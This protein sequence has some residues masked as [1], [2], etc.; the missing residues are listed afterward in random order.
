MLGFWA[1][2]IQGD[3]CSK[4]QRTSMATYAIPRSGRYVRYPAAE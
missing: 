1:G 4:G 2:F 3:T